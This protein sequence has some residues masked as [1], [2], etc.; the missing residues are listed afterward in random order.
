MLV[1]PETGAQRDAAGPEL[2]VLTTDAAASCARWFLLQA[3]LIEGLLLLVRGQ[4]DPR[5][6]VVRTI[7][8]LVTAS[9]FYCIASYAVL[10]VR[11]SDA[12]VT[13]AALAAAIVFRITLFPVVPAFS[14]DI[15][16]YRWEGKLQASGGNPYRAAPNDPQWTSLRDRTFSRMVGGDFKAAYG[17]LTEIIEAGTYRIAATFTTDPDKQVFWFKVPAALFDLGTIIAIMAWLKARRLPLER[18]VI[19][20]WSPLAIFSFWVDG[21]NDPVMLFF[22]ATAFAFGARERW[23]I[24]FAALAL[25]GAAKIWPLLLVPIFLRWS[26]WKWKDAAVMLPVFGA[27][28]LPYRGNFTENLQ[29]ISG[30]AGGW[31]NNDSLYGALLWIASGDVYRAKYL[32]LGIMVALAAAGG[33][34]RWRAE[35]AGL[36]IIVGM[37]IVSANCHPWYPVWF[38]PLLAFVPLAPLFLWTALMPLTFSVVIRWTLLREWDGSTGFRW[39]VYVPV[40]AWLIVAAVR[41]A[42]AKYNE[43]TQCSSRY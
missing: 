4:G 10:K 16:R 6:T 28:V 13:A 20:A 35:A 24:A 25:A 27:C 1:S 15:F 22:I 37:L 26:G 2:P 42:A 38:V 32:A 43:D 39:L 8:L 41:R 14:D 12:R 17:P 11:C 34:I 36:L 29:F 18:V 23:R 40:F 9:V 3:I 33:I 31:R 19:Y 30:F 7:V 21:H 5:L